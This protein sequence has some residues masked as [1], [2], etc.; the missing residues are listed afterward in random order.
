MNRILVFGVILLLVGCD[1]P[2]HPTFGRVTNKEFIPEHTE[3]VPEMALNFD[4]DIV[5]NTKIK[6]VDDAWYVT[7]ESLVEE[8]K[9]KDQFLTSTFEIPKTTYDQIN[10][11]GYYEKDAAQ[12]LKECP[13]EKES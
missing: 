3:S 11:N 10:V 9:C 4:G 7:I 12:S 5:L 8:P 2:K 1:C 13:K 6:T